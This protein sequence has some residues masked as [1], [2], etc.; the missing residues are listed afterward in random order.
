MG[1]SAIAGGHLEN[2]APKVGSLR[3]VSTTRDSLL[4][5]A[6]VNMTNPT[7]Y[8]ATVP[9][10][11]VNL[12]SNGTL[13][14]SATA[15]NIKVVPGRNENMLVRAKWEPLSTSGKKGVEAGKELLSQYIS[16]R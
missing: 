13:L 14:G 9:Y 16:G 10:V 1:D 3:I 6:K 5:E 7:N 4:I 11:N 2:F 12:L 15:E 8:S